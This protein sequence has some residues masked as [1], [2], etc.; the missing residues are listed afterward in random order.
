MCG[1]YTKI[2]RVVVFLNC[3]KKTKFFI[4]T[5]LGVPILNTEGN[6]LHNIIRSY[7][8]ARFDNKDILHTLDTM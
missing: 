4:C 6:C 5:N 1:P 7:V 3:L 2:K 8:I